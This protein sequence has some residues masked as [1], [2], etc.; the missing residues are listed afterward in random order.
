MLRLLRSEELVSQ[1]A[2]GTLPHIVAQAAEH[3][4]DL[5][6]RHLA[7]WEYGAALTALRHAAGLAPQPSALDHDLGQA[8]FELGHVDA[9]IEAFRRAARADDAAL[10]VAALRSIAITIPGAPQAD[11]HAVLA[12][13]RDW[14]PRSVPARPREAQRGTKLRI[15]YVSAFFGS[16]NWMKPVWGLVNNH[17]RTRF[18]VHMFSD[19]TDPSADSGY[20]DAA[21]DV[22]HTVHGI[23]NARLAEII[24]SVGIDIL[25]DLNGYSVTD[26]L[27]LFALRPAPVIVGWFN[28]FA[29]TG[30]AAF[31]WLVGDASVILPD[32]EIHYTE[33]IHRVPASYLAF[34]VSYPVPPVASP[35]SMRTG[36]ITFGCLGSQHKLTDPVLVAWGQI[37]RSAPTARLLVRNATLEDASSRDDLLARLAREGINAARVTL[38]GRADHLDFLRTY[39]RIDIALDT[40]PYNGGTTTTEALWQG[41]PVLTFNGDR[42]ASRTSRSI[43]L[44]AGFP[45]WVRCDVAD[46]HRHAT[47]LANDPETPRM[48]AALR[49]GMRDRL[50]GS[51]ACDTAALCRDMETFYQ[52]IATGQS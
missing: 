5:G 47:A 46:Y 40:F 18:E 16:R 29:T 13:R 3:W 36:F 44:A 26:R 30:M 52:Q 35:P 51:S 42:W 50:R 19:R 28:M 41:V 45:E 39:D 21:Q 14:S 9:A 7:R 48:L 6:R 2:P 1:S 11:D 24:A 20:R 25:V 37:L 17:D 38:E 8:L 15:G 22:I 43:L 12:A 27:G 23:D 34:D 49:A 32:E 31:D 10:R 4:H 33:R